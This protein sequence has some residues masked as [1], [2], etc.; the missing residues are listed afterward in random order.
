MITIK[1]KNSMYDKRHLYGCYIPEFHELTGD[2]I[3]N[4]RW[5][6]DEHICFMTEDK[7]TP[8]RIIKKANIVSQNVPVIAVAKKPTVS[9]WKIAGSKNNIY[10]VR[11]NNGH[12]DC[13]CVGFSFRKDCKHIHEV[14]KSKAA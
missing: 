5:V 9:S 8:L 13:E 12:Y 14:K 4:T 2:I 11:L 10:T 7:Y 3:P 6:D 1:I